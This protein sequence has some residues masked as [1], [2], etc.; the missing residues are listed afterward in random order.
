MTTV[1]ADARAGVMVADTLCLYGDRKLYGRKVTR[2]NGLLVATAGSSAD[3]DSFLEW[4]KNGRHGKPPRMSNFEA[5]ILSSEGV[6]LVQ[7]DCRAVRVER[8]FDAIGTGGQVALGALV[9]GAGPREA[10][11]IACELDAGSGGK[12]EVFKLRGGE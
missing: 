3:G 7:G 4:V 10:V 2:I 1:L 8:G 9:A 11:R 5:L 12:I 6:H